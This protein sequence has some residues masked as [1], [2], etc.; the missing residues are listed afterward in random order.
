MLRVSVAFTVD[1]GEVYNPMCDPP[2]LEVAWDN[3]VAC[4]VVADTSGVELAV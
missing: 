3:L 4:K 2:V 1:V